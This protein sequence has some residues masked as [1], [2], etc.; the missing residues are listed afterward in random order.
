M[1][2]SSEAIASECTKNISFNAIFTRP[3]QQTQLQNFVTAPVDVV[4]A[5]YDGPRSRNVLHCAH[6]P[7]L[8]FEKPNGCGPKDWALSGIRLRIRCEGTE[9]DEDHSQSLS[10]AG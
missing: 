6:R 5:V 4:G 7:R 3:G 2:P 1:S 10:E 9:A 8:Q